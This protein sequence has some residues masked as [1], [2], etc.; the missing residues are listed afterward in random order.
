MGNFIHMNFVNYAIGF[1]VLF[2]SIA[3][4][5]NGTVS[6]RKNANSAYKE[7]DGSSTAKKSGGEIK[8]TDRYSQYEGKYAPKDQ[9]QSQ[10]QVITSIPE[11]FPHPVIMVIP[12]LNSKGLSGLQ[13]VTN[14]PLARAAMDG[15]NEYLTQRRYE[16]KYLEGN[17]ALDKVIQ[18]Q[19]S[20]ASSD[21]DLAYLASLVLNADVYIKFSGSVDRRG[22]VTVELNAYESSTARLLGTQNSTIDS[23]GRMEKI[24]QQANL[25]TAAKKAMPGLESK[26]YAYWADDLREGNKYKVI[27]NI[28]GDYDDSQIE[29]VEEDIVQNVKTKFKKAKVNTMTAKTIDM[30]VYSDSDDVNDVYS[31]IRKAVKSTASTKKINITK[32][33]IIMDVL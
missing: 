33:L 32:K 2:A 13:V 1:L 14:N 7:L 17:E 20:L 28:R 25:K 22:I 21:E 11:D 29:D 19:N 10:P 16:V 9:P 27:M 3:A 6:T 23:H 26:I 31:Q 4:A 18:V 8:H 30:V 5:D 15:I 24:D 12:A